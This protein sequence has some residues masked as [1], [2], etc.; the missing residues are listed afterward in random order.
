[1]S[2]YVAPIER[3]GLTWRAHGVSFSALTDDD[4]TEPSEA[5]QFAVKTP[6]GKITVYGDQEWVRYGDAAKECEGVTMMRD[7]T[8]IFGP[9]REV[10]A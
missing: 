7:I 3:D 1:M 2:G 8:F 4:C 10:H 9:W 6:D 5:V